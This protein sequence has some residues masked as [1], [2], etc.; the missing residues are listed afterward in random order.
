MKIKIIA[1]YHMTKNN[2]N[3]NNSYGILFYIYLPTDLFPQYF[4]YKAHKKL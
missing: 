3:L 4:K 1:V 2:R